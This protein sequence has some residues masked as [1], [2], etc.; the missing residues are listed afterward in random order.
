MVHVHV[1]C[2]IQKSVKWGGAHRQRVAVES[3]AEECARR[4][5]RRAVERSGD[6]RAAERR[7]EWRWRGR[8]TR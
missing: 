4:D 5:E 7:D 1:V 3:E 6:T 2:K 8:A